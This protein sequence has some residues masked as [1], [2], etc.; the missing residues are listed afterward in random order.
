MRTARPANPSVDHLDAPTDS[1]A[2]RN[3]ELLCAFGV[4][5]DVQYADIA[6]GTSYCG[7]RVRRYR[8]SLEILKE[9][10]RNPQRLICGPDRR[11]A[12]VPAP[13][14]LL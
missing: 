7:T 12:C 8:R 6:D 3:P 9:A 1:A 13:G 4:I 11:S 10:V 14:A 2:E 5:A